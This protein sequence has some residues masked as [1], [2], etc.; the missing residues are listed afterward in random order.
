MTSPTCLTVLRLIAPNDCDGNPMRCY[1]ALGENNR[2]LGA[3]KEGYE[4]Y[5]ATPSCIRELT[6]NSFR[7]S[8][9]A[10]EVIYHLNWHDQLDE[11][12]T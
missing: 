11:P 10:E 6:A 8:C 9:S 7:I 3:W 1:V 12:L 5:N 2:F 4:G